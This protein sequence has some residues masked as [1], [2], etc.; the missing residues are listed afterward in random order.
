[1]RYTYFVRD[2]NYK[3]DFLIVDLLYNREIATT[4]TQVNAVNITTALNFRQNEV[5]V[6]LSEQD[7]TRISYTDDF[8]SSK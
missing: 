8:P 3:R 2:I 5:D 1:M 7:R 6:L 4:S